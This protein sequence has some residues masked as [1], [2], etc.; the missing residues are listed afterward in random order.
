MKK[1]YKREVA[2]GMLMFLGAIFMASLHT[3]EL[4]G[5][6]EYLTTPIFLFAT[7]AFGADAYAKQVTT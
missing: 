3:P 6:A 4:L 5:I 2:L 7:A 1:T